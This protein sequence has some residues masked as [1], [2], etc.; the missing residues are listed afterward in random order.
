MNYLKLF[1]DGTS[2]AVDVKP[3]WGMYEKEHALDNREVYMD[4]NWYSTTGGE[5]VT[6]GTFD[7][8]VSGWNGFYYNG[9]VYAANSGSAVFDN[10]TLKLIN[11]T[12]TADYSGAEQS[13][14][15]VVGET[16]T[17]SFNF[18]SAVTAHISVGESTTIGVN[19]ASQEMLYKGYI[20]AGTHSYTFV[21]TS[22]NAYIVFQLG[23]NVDSS[24]LN[25]DN[26]SVYKAEP[27]IDTLQPPHTYLSNKGKLAGIEVAN[28]IPVDIHYN[29]LAPTLVE[30]TIKA[31]DLVTNTLTLAETKWSNADGIEYFDDGLLGVPDTSFSSTGARLYPDGTIRGKSDYG[32]YIKSPDGEA[33]ASLVDATILG[34]G[35]QVFFP[36]TIFHASFS[37]SSAGGSFR[38]LQVLTSSNTSLTLLGFNS[39]G[40]AQNVTL[41]SCDING[42]WK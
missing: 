3:T 37:F 6:N 10:S 40:T 15:C 16:Y 26:I 24:F 31:T 14:T 7:T 8:D 38:H 34:T 29:E 22:V 19:S 36:T 32:D 13:I 18:A 12:G 21:A 9:S 20:S 25:I 39:S 2:E 17:I 30:D 35:T 4:G 28:G 1:E 11:G 41:I 5:L 33:S 27:T 23:V 42:E